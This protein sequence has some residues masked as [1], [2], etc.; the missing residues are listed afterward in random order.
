MK[1]QTLNLKPY[2]LL[3]NKEKSKC[4]KV[5]SNDIQFQYEFLK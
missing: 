2:H 3:H 1:P 4:V 5:G